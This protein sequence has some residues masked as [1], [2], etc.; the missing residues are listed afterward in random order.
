MG[1]VY[2]ARED[3]KRFV[4]IKD[5]ATTDDRNTPASLV[6]VEHWF[7]ELKARAAGR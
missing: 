1:R 5:T 4:A 2:R 3:G 6:V 7:E